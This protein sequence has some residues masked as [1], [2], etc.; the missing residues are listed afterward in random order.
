METDSDGSLP[1]DSTPEPRS[2]FGISHPSKSEQ[3]MAFPVF[4]GK[5]SVPELASPGTVAHFLW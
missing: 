4:P 3:N 1:P 5:R 2:L